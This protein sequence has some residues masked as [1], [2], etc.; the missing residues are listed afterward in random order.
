MF[1]IM[2]LNLQ[3]FAAGTLVNATTNYVNSDTG[4]TTEFSGSNTL[5]PTMKTYYDTELLENARSELIF[6]QFGR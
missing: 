4:A 6:T 3:L 1:E 5:S 2:N